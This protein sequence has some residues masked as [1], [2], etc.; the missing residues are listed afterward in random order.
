MVSFIEPQ[1]GRVVLKLNTI[2]SHGTMDNVEGLFVLCEHALH[3]IG[4]FSIDVDNNDSISELARTTNK[5]KYRIALQDA[6]NGPVRRVDGTGRSLH[7]PTTSSATAASAGVSPLGR[8]S[9]EEQREF[10]E[11]ELEKE[12][13]K[14]PHWHSSIWH[15][16]K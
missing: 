2:L 9:V 16:G 6:S 11:I 4:H 13:K 14:W 1:D 7:H 10:D 12:N 15:Q 5:W 8:S 3:F